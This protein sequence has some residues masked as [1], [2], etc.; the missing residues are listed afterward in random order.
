V[1]LCTRT[2]RGRASA[3]PIYELVDPQIPA[4]WANHG[5]TAGGKIAVGVPLLL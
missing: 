4:I 5:R 3:T 2:P 1:R